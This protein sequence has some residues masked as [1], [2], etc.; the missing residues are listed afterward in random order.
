MT[1]DERLDQDLSHLVQQALSLPRPRVSALMADLAERRRREQAWQAFTAAME[2]AAHNAHRMQRLLAHSR[3][4]QH[5]ALRSAL[6][7]GSA[8]SGGEKQR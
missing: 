5:Q 2:Q 7:A 1:P 8:L 4:R 3:Q 6:T